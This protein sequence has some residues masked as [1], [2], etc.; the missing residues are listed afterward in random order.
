MAKASGCSIAAKWPPRGI[1]LQRRMSVKMSAAIE[2]GWRVNQTV[3]GRNHAANR[4]WGEFA[5][6]IWANSA[7]PFTDNS[8][9]R[10]AT[11]TC[12]RQ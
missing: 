8:P 5:H 6:G 12:A 1:A 3:G 2:R 7:S 4:A 9:L 10:T 11:L